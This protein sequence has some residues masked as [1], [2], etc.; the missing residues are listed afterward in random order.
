MKA[1][2]VIQS[3][4][5]P[6]LGLS[7]PRT[8]VSQYKFIAVISPVDHWCLEV[9]GGAGS[10]GGRDGDVSRQVT[11]SRGPPVLVLLFDDGSGGGVI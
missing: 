6:S 9:E 7:A 5:H 8:E 3:W 4:W 11:G 1:S 2:R 10:T